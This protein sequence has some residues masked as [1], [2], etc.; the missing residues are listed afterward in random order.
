V[1]FVAPSPA[2]R[3]RHPV[4]LCVVCPFPPAG[5]LGS[6]KRKLREYALLHRTPTRIPSARASGFPAPGMARVGSAVSDRRA[7][8]PVVLRRP[9]SVVPSV[10][11]VTDRRA[12]CRAVPRP[13]CT[14]PRRALRCLPVSACWIAWKPEAQAEGIRVAPPD[15][16][17]YSLGSRLGLPGTR[18]GPRW[19]RVP[20]GRA[21]GP[22]R[23]TRLILCR[24][25]SC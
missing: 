8:S 24:A 7:R 1:P 15:T 21:E 19:S 10:A 6:P 13:S 20:P 18:H 17:P 5:L 22:C 11:A 23:R 2:R 3:A 14:A 25:V 9:A 4:V 16:D 12:F